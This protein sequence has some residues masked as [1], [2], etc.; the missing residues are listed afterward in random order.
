V[1][2]PGLETAL[3]RRSLSPRTLLAKML[4]AGATV[5]DVGCG[6]FHKTYN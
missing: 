4:P 5:L 1:S 6:D 3:A 2:D